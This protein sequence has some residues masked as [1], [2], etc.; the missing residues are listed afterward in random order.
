[1]AGRGEK[2]IQSSQEKG[3]SS[4][5]DH[6]AFATEESLDLCG[7]GLTLLGKVKGKLCV[8]TSRNW[9]GIKPEDKQDYFLAEILHNGPTDLRA[10]GTTQV[11]EEQQ[12]LLDK[13]DWKPWP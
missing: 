11:T 13:L 6:K 9:T 10:G 7:K 3:D 1:M 12:E 5:A 4:M 2:L 8:I